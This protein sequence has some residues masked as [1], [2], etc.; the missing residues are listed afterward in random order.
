MSS[1]LIF[2]NLPWRA[3]VKFQPIVHLRRI[4]EHL[5]M[6][7]HTQR[8]SLNSLS[9]WSLSE[10]SSTTQSKF[11]SPENPTRKKRDRFWE[12]IFKKNPE[13]CTWHFW[14]TLRRLGQLD[15]TG[16]LQQSSADIAD[17]KLNKLRS[18]SLPA[19]KLKALTTRF[20]KM[21]DWCHPASYSKI[22]RGAQ[23]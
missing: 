17:L 7:L 23:L 22:Y 21:R 16:T 18:N 6:F 8:V 19:L 2:Q 10:C 9:I 20:Q 11:L 4:C 5:V 12:I 3:A 1:G 13:A 15:D 14:T